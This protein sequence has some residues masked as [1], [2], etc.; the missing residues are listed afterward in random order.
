MLKVEQLMKMGHSQK[1]ARNI[2]F[3]LG[4]SENLEQGKTVVR[5]WKGERDK[6]GVITEAGVK[7]HG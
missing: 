1:E 3:G 6:G 5:V 4:D 2:L 7:Y